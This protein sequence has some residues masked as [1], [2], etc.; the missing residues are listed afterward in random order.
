MNAILFSREAVIVAGLTF[1]GKGV[2]LWWIERGVD[3]DLPLY[4]MN[5]RVALGGN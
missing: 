5:V 4:N 1:A 3:G 2:R